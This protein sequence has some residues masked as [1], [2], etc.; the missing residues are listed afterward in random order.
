MTLARRSTRI[1]GL[2]LTAAALA[3]S[4]A[5]SQPVDA[6]PRAATHA[7][8]HNRQD[9]RSADAIDAAVRPA[10]ARQD[11]RSPD[12]VD[13]AIR[14]QRVSTPDARP[15]SRPA[16]HADPGVTTAMTAAILSG[17]L[18]LLGLVAALVIRTHRTAR[19]EI[20]A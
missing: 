12:T 18:L 16:E 7:P 14:A 9:L 17:G 19:S 2:A 5:W 4:P 10:P 1:L 6:G 8:Q 3:A 15:D 13:A 20:S 11:L